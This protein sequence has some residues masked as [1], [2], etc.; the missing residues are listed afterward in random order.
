MAISAIVETEVDRKER[1]RRAVNERLKA[2]GEPHSIGQFLWHFDIDTSAARMN[3]L[4]LK[5]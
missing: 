4:H 2:I 5:R 3:N 1:I